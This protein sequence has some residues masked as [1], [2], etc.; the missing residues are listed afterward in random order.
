MAHPEWME[1]DNTPEP[2]R[3]SGPTFSVGQRVT[4]TTDDEAGYVIE[5]QGEIRAL[6]GRLALVVIAGRSERVPLDRIKPA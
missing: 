5:L 1:R 6:D 4:V 3:P 2:I